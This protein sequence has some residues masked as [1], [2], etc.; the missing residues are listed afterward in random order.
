MVLTA[1]LAGALAP[2]AAGATS[3]QNVASTHAYL[4]DSYTVLHAAVSTWPSVEASIHRLELRFH[5]ECPDVGAGSPQNEEEQKLSYEVAGAL[6]ATGYH[7]DATILRT[8]VKS[9]ARLT[10]SNPR[11]TRDAHRLARGLREMTALRVPNICADVRAWQADGFGAMPSDVEP[12]DQHVEAIDIHEIPRSL[13]IPYVQPADRGLR[14]RAEH[15]AT[16]FA[17]LEFMR[18]QAD[19]VTLLEVVGLNE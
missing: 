8:Y 7:T 5:A 16:R 2:T 4:V 9:L 12:Y 6:W 15:L 3:Q 11:I 17:E 10:W 14:E 18:G 19:W 13:L 1:M